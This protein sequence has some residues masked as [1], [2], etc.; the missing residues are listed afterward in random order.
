[1]SAGS[2]KSTDT[3]PVT[4]D[5]FKKISLTATGDVDSAGTKFEIQPGSS[6]IANVKCRIELTDTLWFEPG[7]GVTE[8][9]PYQFHSDIEKF[10]GTLISVEV[11]NDQLDKSGT[12]AN[13]TVDQ[14][15]FV[16]FGDYP[17]TVARV[18][19]NGTYVYEIDSRKKTVGGMD[20][21]LGEDGGYYV[22]VDSAKRG[23]AA[24]DNSQYKFSDGTT[25]SAFVGKECWF[26]VEPIVWRVLST[27]HKG[28]AL[29]WSVKALDRIP[30]FADSY[31]PDVGN[32]AGLIGGGKS[33]RT[34]GDKE[35]KW[36]NYKYSTLRA[37]LRGEYET[38]DEQSLE[39]YKQIYTG[40]SGGN[41]EVLLEK[42]YKDGEKRGFLQ[43]A[44]DSSSQSLL[45]EIELDDVGTKDCIFVLGHDELGIKEPEFYFKTSELDVDSQTQ[46]RKQLT[47]YTMAR[48]G[49]RWS[50]TNGGIT[51]DYPGGEIWTRTA[52]SSEISVYSITGFGHVF[53]SSSTT[54]IGRGAY[55][56]M[57][58]VPAICVDA[59]AITTLFP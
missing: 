5:I 19:G 12:V 56:A 37:F 11:L 43:R 53:K 42:F 18:D 59:S 35:I 36:G 34:I 57:S 51:V 4:S 14:L 27:N 38:G 46:R 9:K 32:G 20:M 50:H 55:K 33:I 52:P 54:G 6:G 40:G 49:R 24:G 13:A 23:A 22:K 39:S 29:L 28:A 2:K 21:Y 7:F 45:V 30:Y 44:F 16:T 26:K 1:M 48:E 15:K 25:A 31:S 17:Q 10:T 41:P 3:Y 58:V 8:I 47:D